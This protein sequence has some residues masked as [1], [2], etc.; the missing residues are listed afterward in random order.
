M[1]HGIGLFVWKD[2]SSYEGDWF[3]DKING[4]GS[5]IWPDGRKYEGT[6]KNNNMHG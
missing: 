3:E 6:W 5:Y 4:V 1:R 2:G